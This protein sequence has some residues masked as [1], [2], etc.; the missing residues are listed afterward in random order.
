MSADALVVSGSYAALDICN[1]SCVKTMHA[2]SAS[3]ILMRCMHGNVA[4]HND[5][6]HGL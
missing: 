4:M 1:L 5:A 6:V 2:F 3:Y